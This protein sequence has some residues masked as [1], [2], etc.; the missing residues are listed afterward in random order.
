MDIHGIV[1]GPQCRAF[2]PS[3]EKDGGN[4][5]INGFDRERFCTWSTFSVLDH[6]GAYLNLCIPDDD[7]C[8]A[9]VM[10]LNNLLARLNGDTSLGSTWGSYLWMRSR[11]KC[12]DAADGDGLPLSEYLVR[13]I[14][15]AAEARGVQNARRLFKARLVKVRKLRELRKV[16]ARALAG[17]VGEDETAREEEEEEYFPTAEELLQQRMQSQFKGNLEESKRKALEQEKKATAEATA[18]ATEKVD[19]E[20]AKALRR[21]E[22]KDRAEAAEDAERNMARPKMPCREVEKGVLYSKIKAVNTLCQ[23]QA[24]RRQL[25]KARDGSATLPKI[26]KGF[27]THIDQLE[28]QTDRE[29]LRKHV[30]MLRRYEDELQMIIDD[31]SIPLD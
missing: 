23:K 22:Q 24:F 2:D 12:K 29:S 16:D 7:K 31:E 6:R 13:G 3:P 11:T 1:F 8:M 15:K 5:P 18:E 27:E 10:G 28:K 20:R 30:D 19:R 14:I 4:G 26:I 9:W 21:K 25:G 17:F